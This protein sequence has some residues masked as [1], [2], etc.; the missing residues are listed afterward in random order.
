[1]RANA[2]AKSHAELD[3]SPE[4]DVGDLGEFAGSHASL[5]PLVADLR[6]IGGC[7]GTDYRHIAAI[8]RQYFG[9][10]G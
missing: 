6:L 3:E 10:A 1:M 7:C 4:I 2:S 8:C 5:L 9:S